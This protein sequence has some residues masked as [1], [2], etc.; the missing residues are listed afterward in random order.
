MCRPTKSGVRREGTEGS[1]AT[2]P[3]PALEPQSNNRRFPEIGVAGA[4]ARLWGERVPA[5]KHDSTSA[6]RPGPAIEPPSPSRHPCTVSECL[7]ETRPGVGLIA[8]A[9]RGTRTDHPCGTP[10]TRSPVYGNSQRAPRVPALGARS[11][12]GL[13]AYRPRGFPARPQTARLE[14]KR[15]AI[16]TRPAAL[17]GGQRSRLS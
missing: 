6:T 9:A 16:N 3:R 13:S 4:N 17:R 14:S 11:L 1:P 10:L 15:Y 5:S 8:G 7:S 12:P 2:G